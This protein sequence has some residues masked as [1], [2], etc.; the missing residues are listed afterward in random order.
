MRSTIHAGLTYNIYA[1][2]H[3]DITIYLNFS[4]T[5]KD[6]RVSTVISWHSIV[7][8][9]LQRYSNHFTDEK[10]KIGT[11][12]SAVCSRIEYRIELGITIQIWI[13]SRIE[14]AVIIYLLKPRKHWRL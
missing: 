7:L 4:S 5:A 8:T 14:S 12:E 2:I 11:C 13:E 9:T 1:R 6:I 10:W 3:T